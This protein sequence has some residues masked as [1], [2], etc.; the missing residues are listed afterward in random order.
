MKRTLVLASIVP[1]L[2]SSVV[3][4]NSASQ[5]TLSLG[6][7]IYVD[8][9]NIAGPWDGTLDHP[10]HD[11]QDGID[12]ASNGDTVYVF[13]GTYYESVCINKSLSLV[14]ESV[15][16]TLIDSYGQST[17]VHIVSHNVLFDSFTLQNSSGCQNASGILL[18]ANT[19][20]IKN[21][22][23]QKTKTGIVV[24]HHMLN[25]INNCTFHHNG[26]GI[27]FN[28]TM[29]NSIG[30]CCFAYNALGFYSKDS[31]YHSLQYSYWY[32]NGIACY[33][34]SSHYYTFTHCNMSDNSDNHGGLF[35]QNCSEITI[36]D[37]NFYHNGMGIH[38]ENSHHITIS[39][40]SLLC[41]THFALYSKQ[42][43]QDIQLHFCDI[44][45]NLRY[46]VY[47]TE[48]SDCTLRYCNVVDTYL[49]GL[50][51][52]NARCTAVHNWWGSPLGPRFFTLGQGTRISLRPLLIRYFPW[53]LIP[54]L[55][56]GSTWQDNEVYL[57]KE[58]PPILPK[59]L[60]L[61]GLDSDHDAVPDWWEEKW[62]Y[63][64]NSWD[65]HEHLDP[66]GDGLHNIE[67]CY[68]DQWGSNP[69]QKD[70]FLEIDWTHSSYN[71][72][73]DKPS[74]E[75][76]LELSA[77][78]ESHGITLHI[79]TGEL[80]G[81]EQIP[82]MDRFSFAQ[83]RDIYWSYFLHNDIDHPRKG[84]FHYAIIC[85]Y[86]PDVNFPFVGWDHLDSALISAQWLEDLLPTYARDR[87]I[88]GA[89]VHQLGSSLGLLVDTH[90]G[91]DNLETLKPFSFQW[92]RYFNYR[93]CMNYY[94]KYRLFSYSDGTHGCGDFDDWNHL[95]FSFFK[96]SYF[97]RS[98][99]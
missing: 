77:I 51:V 92:F 80:G 19:T 10:F 74:V 33:L 89:L 63:D 39:H 23:I 20:E 17:V 41:N 25:T 24:N 31:H 84:I 66:D 30:G 40:C 87:L 98:S 53:N 88:V 58:V 82:A 14:G 91:N 37:S 54:F 81:G 83:L 75:L 26:Q 65:D 73:S 45:H 36:K 22:L 46:G 42:Y 86:G 38:L 52:D 50:S 79:D 28:V 7:V 15:K 1:L 96:Q 44:A 69:F 71:A 34:N 5:I 4:S 11:I 56:A 99:S 32:A 70:L 55:D 95:N 60:E 43:S 61:S 90:G 21:C 93:S 85:D 59:T 6:E 78:F 97:T 47:L 35:L 2:L 94:Y 68:T 13:N 29:Y 49:L 67:E 27:F 9:D 64:A 3:I 48:Q 8:D 12:A 16:S 57:E 18:E 62:Q 76:L 72:A